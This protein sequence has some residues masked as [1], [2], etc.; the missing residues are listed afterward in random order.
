MRKLFIAVI[1][2]FM[3][4]SAADTAVLDNSKITGYKI[5]GETENYLELNF[6][7]KDISYNDVSTEKGNFTRIGI[8]S[9]TLTKEAGYP[10]MPAYNRMIAMPFGAEAEIEVVSY[11][12]K[13]YKLSDL[14]IVN[15][16]MPAQPSY[17]KSAKPEDIKFIYNESAYV[18]SK[19]NESP[20][21]SVTKSGTMRGIGV[22]VVS[23]EPIRYNP[24]TGEILVYNNI[25]IRV[26][27]KGADA[28]AAEI[29]KEEY[30]PFFE[31]AYS[32]LVNYKSLDTKADITTYPVT[33]LILA[34]SGLNGNA[35]LNRLIAWKKEKGFNV[36]VNYVSASSTITTN[37]TWIENQYNTL[38][39]KPSFVLVVGDHDG[40]YGVLSEVNPPLGSTGSV[41]RSDLLYGVI[42][43]TSSTNKIP[44]MYV[45]RF[46]VRALGE[47]TAQVDKTLWYEKEQFL[48]TTPDLNYLTYTLGV[49][50]VDASYAANFGDPQIY[51]GWNYY[52]NAANGMGNS[53]T[54]FSNESNA[55][56]ADL[57]I[58]N[59][60]SAGA[61][62]YNYTAHGDIT[63]FYDPN[64]TNTHVDAMTNTNKYPIMV[65][66]CCLTGSF[67]TTEC[68]G[69][70]LL[71]AP[72]KGAVGYIGASMSTYW[73]E[74]LTMGVGMDVNGQS[75]P[76][77]DQA[78]PGMY[79]GVMALGYSSLGAMKHV[80]LMAVD[81]NNQTYEDDYWSSYHTFGDPSLM[82]YLGIPGTMTATHDGVIA[83]GVTTYTVTTTPYAYVAM[84]DASGVLHGAARANSS[85]VASLTIS[86]YTVGDTGKLV[87]TAQFKKPYFE[88]VLC[89][90][91]T[92]GTFAYTP[93]S[94]SYGSVSLGSSL[95]K[96]FQ[97]SNSHSSEYLLGDITTIVGYTVTLASKDLSEKPIKDAK[98]TMSYSVAPQSSKTFNLT[99][100]PT[101]AGTYNGNITITSTDTNHATQYLA[102][103]GTGIVPDINLNPTSLSATAAPGAS[104]NKAFAVENTDLGTLNY[105]MS[106]NYTGGKEIKGS[107]GPDTFGYKW[108]DS[109][110][111]G[112][113]VYSW[114]DITGSGSTVSL[115]DDAYS[116]ALNLGFTF[117]FYGVDYTSVKICSNGFLSFTS[118]VTA[119]TNGNIPDTATPNDVLALFWDD[120]NPTAGGSIYYYADSA[121]GR[122]IVSYIGI[123]HYSTTSYNTAQVIIYSSGKIV[124]Q[125]Q[126]VGA[127]TVSTC[128]V[129]IENVDGTDGLLVIKDAAYLKANLAIQFQATPEWL[130]LNSTS[131]SIV[132]VGSNNIT[133]TCDAT[134]LEAGVYTADIIIG[135]NDPDEATKIL[136]VTFTVTDA[137]PAYPDITVS[138]AQI[139]AAA[140]PEGT[141][142]DSFNIGNAGTADLNYTISQEY[143]VAKADI[144]VHSNDFESGLVYTNS[145]AVSWAVASGMS[146]NCATATG[147]SN[148][149]ALAVLTS[150][151]FDGTGCTELTLNFDQIISKN[152]ARAATFVVEY[153]NGSAWIEIYNETVSTSI[154]QSL[155]LPV[156]A[157]N[158]QIK[159][160]ANISNRQGIDTWSIDNVVVYGPESSPGYS[161]LTINSA[162]S[163]TVVPAGS[164]TINLTCDAAGLTANTY[165]ANITVD[166]DDPDEASVVIPVVFV[167]SS[168]TP[169][170]APA[171][172]TVVTATASEVNIGWDAVSGATIYHIY[173]STEPYS[174][175]TEIGTSGTNGYQDTDVLSGNKY[176]Y[177]I[178][179]D[180]AKK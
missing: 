124:Y 88:D 92:G 35:D 95:V 60:M 11:E 103:T 10:A 22:G 142:T 84:G 1:S 34:N 113:P 30:S 7:L 2:I 56:T 164:N 87:I 112:G 58:R 176:F 41:T 70:A 99:F 82:P 59:F 102:V 130:S 166:S 123:P 74:D 140:E 105:S 168:A 111:V 161:W 135:S 172:T 44:S 67:G 46:S 17:S 62:F 180:N 96:T 160:T 40:T 128:T 129:G 127:S 48:V 42:G 114:V 50:G 27:F 150:D 45:G 153:F 121:N 131:G 9:G 26:N 31:S 177:Y 147:N 75:A 78:H 179:S 54:Y 71:N 39:P 143:V 5:T 132:G 100:E 65:G 68:F 91:D 162:L 115:G 8:E 118:T 98:N 33:Y 81:N 15:P 86:P 38:S 122:F 126:E 154:S 85:G 76:A 6:G 116:A 175:F 4:L 94:L 90:G 21:A 110:E 37:D 167:V 148:G 178:T 25:E 169:P 3:V 64:F 61:A 72:D 117:N 157:T 144:N 170:E 23:V 152:S 55:S 107:G 174:G 145:G 141:D 49:A 29:A 47:L 151:I 158:M 53:E 120:M 13:S 159:F 57:E 28:R 109:D 52:F 163:G 104:V 69:E 171:N 80:G 20:I 19:Y 155:P 12:T 134:D 97:I 149:L 101:G 66:N 119:Y 16:I 36:I 14:G 32:K 139:D 18:A 173:R 79:D 108:T 93:G 43:A 51:Y 83:P 63:M 73:N 156:L 138:A 106:I 136:P 24:S 137:P 89:T 146:V 125:Y 165:N 77:L 133:A